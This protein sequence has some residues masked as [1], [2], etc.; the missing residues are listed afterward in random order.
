MKAKEHV[1]NPENKK[2]STLEQ[3]LNSKIKLIMK[4]NWVI[5]KEDFKETKR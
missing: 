1:K 5:K 2:E 4:V 3:L